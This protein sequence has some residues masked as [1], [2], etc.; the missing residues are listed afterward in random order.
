MSVLGID[1]TGDLLVPD[2]TVKLSRIIAKAGWNGQNA[3]LARAVAL[4]ESGGDPLIVNGSGAVGLFQILE[5]AHIGQHGTPKTHDAWV[6][7]MQDPIYNAQFAYWLW[8]DAGQ[9][10]HR[11]WQASESKWGK[12][13]HQS[14]HDDPDVVV[15]KNSITSTAGDVATA[16]AAPFTAVGDLIGALA[17][18]STYLR[19]GKGL[20]GGILVVLGAAAVVYVVASKSPLPAGAVK[21]ILK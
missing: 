6:K 12:Y 18:P 19:I 17:D 9:D 21:A 5:R 3:Q 2:T 16:A 4:A 11:D 20:L 10:F 8:Q 7:H 13:R 15:K 1:P 14:V